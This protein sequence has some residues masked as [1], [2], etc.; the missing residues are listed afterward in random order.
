MARKISIYRVIYA[1]LCDLM[2]ERERVGEEQEPTDSVS[3][4]IYRTIR[5]INRSYSEPLSAELCAREVGMSYSY[6]S[7]SFKRITSKSFKE[8]LN[9]VRINNAE[10]LLL[11]GDMSVTE[12]ALEC[13]YT[14]PS[15]FISV[16]RAM[17]GTTPKVRRLSAK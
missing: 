16:Y 2:L 3:L 5:R 7:R 13:G 9:E 11:G 6:F 8:Y 1:F 15:Y 12:I 17:K 14:N 4:L 10:R